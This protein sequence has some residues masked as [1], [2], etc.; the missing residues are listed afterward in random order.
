M[1]SSTFLIALLWVNA[2]RDAGQTP[3]NDLPPCGAASIPSANSASLASLAQANSPPPVFRVPG[4]VH[5]VTQPALGRVTLLVRPGTALT[6]LA[7]TISLA[8]GQTIQPDCGEP[9]DFSQPVAYR[10]QCDAGSRDWVVEVFFKERSF[11]LDFDGRQA[12]ITSEIDMFRHVAEHDAFSLSLWFQPRD[13]ERRQHLFSQG[14][15]FRVDYRAERDQLHFRFATEGDSTRTLIA[16]ADHVRFGRWNHWALVSRALGTST[17]WLNGREVAST[18]SEVRYGDPD[19]SPALMFGAHSSNIRHFAGGLRDFRVYLG[20]HLDEA[21]VR[22]LGAGQAPEPTD[23]F[24][25]WALDEG[26]GATAHDG[27]G[28]GRD[29]TIVGGVWREMVRVGDAGGEPSIRGLRALLADMS[30]WPRFIAAGD[31]L[32]EQGWQPDHELDA[33]RYAISRHDWSAA[34]LRRAASAPLL[35]DALQAGPEPVR[36]AASQGLGRL[37][38]PLASQALLAAAGD[39]SPSVR[40]AVCQALEAIGDPR[41]MRTVLDLLD[42]PDPGVRQAAVGA[43]VRGGDAEGQAPALLADLTGPDAGVRGRAAR[44][45][46]FV[47]AG[48]GADPDQQ[49]TAVVDALCDR[50]DDPGLRDQAAAAL[51]QI[52]GAAARA[53]LVQAGY[54]DAWPMWRYDAARTAFTPHELPR[55]L[56]LAWERS[57]PPPRRAWEPQEDDADKL[58]FDVSYQPVAAGGLLFVPCM[59]RDRV[60]AY[61]AATGEEQWRFTTGGPVRFAPAVVGDRATFVSDDGYLYCVDAESGQMLWRVRGGPPRRRILGNGRLIDTWPARG[62]PV[63]RD[64]LVY[65]TAG[66][67]PSLGIF[68][69]AVQVDTGEVVWT[70][71]GSGSHFAPQVHQSAGSHSGPAPQGYLA[72]EGDLLLAPSGRSRPAAFRR[73]TG[74]FLYFNLVPRP[75]DRYP[76]MGGWATM[77]AGDYFYVHGELNRLS[78]GE[79]LLQLRTPYLEQLSAEDRLQ[80]RRAMQAIDVLPPGDLSV[81]NPEELVG[82]RHGRLTAYA[83]QL[84]EQRMLVTDRRGDQRKVDQHVLQELWSLDTEPAVEQI[85]LQAGSRFYGSG[86]DGAILAIEHP[87]GAAAA[88]CPIL[89]GRVSGRPWS[90]LAS[91]GRL[92]VVTEEG[93]LYCF[94]AEPGTPRRHELPAAGL[95]ER[96]GDGASRAAK[97]LEHSG[98]RAG[99][100]VV[101]GDEI[102]ALI[103]ELLRQTDLHVVALAADATRVTR[104]Q[105]H[106]DEAGVYGSRVA[107][108]EGDLRTAALPPYFAELIVVQE[109]PEGEDAVTLVGRVFESLRPYGGTAWLPAPAG[110]EADQVLAAWSAAAGLEKAE[111]SGHGDWGALTRAGPLPGSGQWTHQNADAA[112][113]LVSAESR[114]RAPLGPLWFG[115]PTNQAVLPRHG[116][117]PVPQV[118]GGRMFLLGP[119]TL[120]ARDV[121][122]G[123]PLWQKSLPGIGLPYD[124]TSHQPGADHVGSPYVSQADAVYVRDEGM[125]LQL[126]PATGQLVRRIHPSGDSGQETHEPLGF[127][128]VWEDLLIVGVEP[129]YF[130][131]S[132][133]GHGRNWNATSSRRVVVLDRQTGRR[134]WEREAEFGFRHNAIATA[135]GRL[136]LVDRLSDGVLDL[137]A[138]RGQAPEGTPQL[139]ALDARTGEVLWSTRQQVFGSWLGYSEEHD[140]L[141]QASRPPVDRRQ[142]LPDEPRPGSQ[143]MAYRG[144]DGRLLW[145]QDFDYR[146]PCLLH[147]DRLIVHG[148]IYS[149]LTGQPYPAMH[150]VTGRE[151]P[152]TYAASSNCGQIIAGQH[153]LTFRRGTASYYDLANAGGTGD[154]GGLRAG[155]TPNMVPAD[156]VLNVPDYTRTCV[157]QYPLQ[158]SLALIPMDEAEQWMIDSLPPPEEPVQRFGANLGARGHRQD[159]SGTLWMAYPPIHMVGGTSDAVPLRDYR[160][161]VGTGTPTQVAVQIAPEHP[162]WV[163]FYEHSSRFTGEEPHWVTASGIKGAESIELS[164]AEDG[165][166]RR[167]TV[168]LYFA[169]PGSAAEG[170]RVFD[171]RLQGEPVGQ[172][173]DIA[174]LAGGA[175]RGW[176][177]QFSGIAVRDQLRVDLEA[178]PRSKHPP[179]L[180]GIEVVRED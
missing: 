140:V 28:G 93:R 128:S 142:A 25:H 101:L 85:L 94:A 55:Q 172:G 8:E 133:P 148:H 145:E 73:S 160:I 5:A 108:H 20:R 1:S 111:I 178:D 112:N 162:G 105:Q 46:G 97:I 10:V 12:R 117:G 98:V 60:T 83:P 164:L 151:G 136:F 166:S 143:L 31:A 35:A 57:L 40:R 135:A 47:L 11:C 144:E 132:R 165:Q 63:I 139:L 44:A 18:Q 177:Q 156:G 9:Q 163:R 45:L 13:V 62:G 74:E 58:A 116:R 64:G 56:D 22:G 33:A 4:Q 154:I 86:P 169:E 49:V 14:A 91:E 16:D 38:G 155:C 146:N 180:C 79:P 78:D 30:D 158:T 170:E 80:N 2:T 53:A 26:R 124:T 15:R 72:A 130:D 75:W 152:W 61:D 96:S 29:G 41:A 159:G 138:R 68:V 39:D 103:E 92:F 118:A 67:W 32:E 149:L 7:P 81:A 100:A 167:Y 125:V 137:L 42:D 65:F 90:M 54:P 43:L 89:I 77:I 102:E 95:R 161:S 106:F 120:S 70:H 24:L 23:L 19:D 123:R 141:V 110:A 34:E 17:M 129:Q 37:G 131:D 87:V 88:E 82:A 114:V 115:G 48:R 104:M 179:V 6:E 173:F 99:Y 76:G 66:I 157:C 147:G 109:M 121:Y 71:S 51:G 171:V 59:V 107:V 153:L 36:E 52:G 127:L 150:P 126:E 175:R 3:E 69:H 174:A 122:T 27:T 168:R 50:L 176:V 21:E 134:L 113:T 119:D 84:R